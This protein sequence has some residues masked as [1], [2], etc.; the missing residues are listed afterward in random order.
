MAKTRKEQL[1]EALKALQQ[2][3]DDGFPA[4][5]HRFS[6]DIGICTSV[7]RYWV[8]QGLNIWDADYIS[9]ALDDEFNGNVYPFN[10]NGCEGYISEANNQNM[11][12]NKARRQWL[13][14]RTQCLFSQ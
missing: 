1:D 12:R 7:R 9:G 11:Y 13:K 5:S 8:Q 4:N 3:I 14:E 6:C 2:W 10:K